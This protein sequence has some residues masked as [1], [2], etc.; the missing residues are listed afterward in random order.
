ME[1]Q[2]IISD[3]FLL[4]EIFTDN[5]IVQ[6]GFDYMRNRLLTIKEA[7]EVLKLLDIP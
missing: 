4:F 1:K 5:E 6:G 2:I 7:E 3:D